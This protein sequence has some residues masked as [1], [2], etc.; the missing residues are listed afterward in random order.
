MRHFMTAVSPP[1][2]PKTVLK[3][4][5]LAQKKLEEMLTGYAFLAPA[6]LVFVI[7]LVLP[8]FFAVFISFTDWDGISTL[9]QTARGASG[10]VEFT[11]ESTEAITIPAGTIVKSAGDEPVEFRTTADVTVPAGETAPAEVV[12]VDDSL[13]KE[14]NVRAKV[15]RVLPPE[16]VEKVTVENPAPVS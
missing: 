1:N 13:G 16:L 8:I 15:V 12:A 3:E 7:F 11:N 5:T 2:K 10:T 4:T 6:I 9:G 14:T